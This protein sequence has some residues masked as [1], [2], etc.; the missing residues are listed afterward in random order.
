VKPQIFNTEIDFREI[1]LELS[2]LIQL[3]DKCLMELY[4]HRDQHSES[5]N[6]IFLIQLETTTNCFNKTT[7]M[8]LHRFKPLLVPIHKVT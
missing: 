7:G 6:G 3:D 2:K 8:S 1:I 4:E 5:T